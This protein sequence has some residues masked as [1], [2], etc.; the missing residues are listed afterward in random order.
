MPEYARKERR[1]K[2][3][4][5]MVQTLARC[6]LEN[7]APVG[8]GLS[9]CYDCDMTVLWAATGRLQT[10]FDDARETQVARPY[11][12]VGI[13]Q[14]SREIASRIAR[15]SKSTQIQVSRP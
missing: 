11:L 6:Q 10:W 3:S 4:L 14:S 15:Q 9:Y 5:D 13:H 8:Q 1:E 7:Q 2:G 12:R